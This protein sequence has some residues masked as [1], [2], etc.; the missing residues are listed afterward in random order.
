MVV[1]GIEGID[2]VLPAAVEIHRARV[3]L[4][5]GPDAVKG[6]DHFPTV[7]VDDFVGLAGAAQA[8]AFLRLALGRHH[9]FRLR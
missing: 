4:E 5:E 6:A 1:F 8:H 2:Q 9:L 7:A 3:S